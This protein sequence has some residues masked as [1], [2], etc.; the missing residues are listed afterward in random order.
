M[1]Y[2]Y[3]PGINTPIF[4]KINYN[5]IFSEKL[6]YE[7]QAWIENHPCSIHYTTA[8][9]SLLVK[10]NGTL[11]NKQKHLPQI[12]VRELQNDM[13]L[14]IYQGGFFGARTVD[15]KLCTVDTSFRKYMPKNTKSNEHQKQYY[16][17]MQ[18]M[19]KCNITSIRYQ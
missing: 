6:V 8:S 1:L 9:D 10:I 19:Y 7:L 2:S 4:Q 17:W 11:V 13:I 14:A 12:S 16:M 15:G 18:N 5:N 3:L